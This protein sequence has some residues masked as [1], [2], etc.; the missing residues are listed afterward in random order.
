MKTI[1][2]IIIV[3]LAAW[4]IWWLAWGR[5]DEVVPNPNDNMSGENTNIDTSTD[6]NVDLSD[7]DSK[8]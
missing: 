6:A 8:G 3:L 4:G 7:F 5:T 2:T 1:I